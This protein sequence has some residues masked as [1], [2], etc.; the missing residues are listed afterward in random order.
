MDPA[1]QANLGDADVFVSDASRFSDQIRTLSLETDL[2][3]RAQDIDALASY[4]NNLNADLAAAV[5]ESEA[6]A[7][8]K[9]FNYTM[10]LYEERIGE[11]EIVLS[12]FG[13]LLPENMELVRT[14]INN[15]AAIFAS[16]A[17]M[18]PSISTD[19][20]KERLFFLNV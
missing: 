16:E 15:S 2:M 1:W 14:T 5:S 6:Q 12:R 10:S 11:A 8:F 13:A 7:L 18:G 20:K 4:V 3:D 9:D 17:S 19:V